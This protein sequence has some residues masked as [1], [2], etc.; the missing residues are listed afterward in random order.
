MS[1]LY[2]PANGMIPL[3]KPPG[4]YALSVDRNLH[5]IQLGMLLSAKYVPI[6]RSARNN[7]P[8]S[9]YLNGVACFGTKTANHALHQTCGL[10]IVLEVL[11]L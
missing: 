7:S 10:F 11:G 3:R 2:L 4:P 8:G 5:G 1:F 6:P 9:S